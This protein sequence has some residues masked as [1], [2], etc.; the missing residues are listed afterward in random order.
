[1]A[2]SM[3]MAGVGS[4]TKVTGINMAVPAAGPTPGSTPIMVPRR[5]PIT[6]N[7]RLA[8]CIAVAKPFIRSP[9]VST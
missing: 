6:A 2:A 8:G 9:K 4:R 3:M 5:H 1:M 7:S